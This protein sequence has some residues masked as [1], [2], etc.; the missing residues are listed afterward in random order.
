MF[1]KL[2]HQRDRQPSFLADNGRRTSQRQGSQSAGS[3]PSRNQVRNGT[4]I[5][6]QVVAQTLRQAHAQAA[7]ACTL[8]HLLSSAERSDFL[9][10]SS[11]Q[12]LLQPAVP[13]SNSSCHTESIPVPEPKAKRRK[14]TA[15]RQVSQHTDKS[16]VTLRVNTTIEIVTTSV[17][18]NEHASDTE[19]GSDTDNGQQQLDSLSEILPLDDLDT[20]EQLRPYLFPQGLQSNT[21]SAGMDGEPVLHANVF[22]EYLT[23]EWCVLTRA[24][25]SVNPEENRSELLGAIADELFML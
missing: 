17:P 25:P 14:P 11:S 19:C 3:A 1:Q 20:L 8:E 23:P 22:H 21:G 24:Q 18:A 10:T 12:P 4:D 15:A 16:T 7:R 6:R 13:Q 9:P 5:T 2:S